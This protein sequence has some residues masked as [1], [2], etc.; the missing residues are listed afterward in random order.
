M[1]YNPDLEKNVFKSLVQKSAEMQ[2]RIKKIDR[3]LDRWIDGEKE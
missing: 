3:S 1:N 2:G